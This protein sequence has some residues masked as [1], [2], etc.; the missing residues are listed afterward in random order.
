MEHMVE[1]RLRAMTEADVAQVTA[2]EQECF[3]DAWSEKLVSDLMGSSY[4]EVWVLEEPDKGIVGYINIRFLAGE[5]ELMRIAVKKDCR[6]R[7]YS[8]KLMDRMMESARESDAPEL[9]LEVRAGNEPAIGL[10]QSYGFV[11]EAVRKGYYHNP[12]ED[13]LIMW[14]HGLPSIPT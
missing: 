7:G 4:D 9:T 13:A 1:V 2:L 11:S 5:G 10:Y 12:T 8:K 14:L 3:S 6:G